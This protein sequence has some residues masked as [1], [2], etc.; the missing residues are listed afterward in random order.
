[1]AFRLVLR[2]SL[3]L[4]LLILL[5][6]ASSGYGLKKDKEEPEDNQSENNKTAS[7]RFPFSW[8]SRK[9]PILPPRLRSTTTTTT[10]TTTTTTENSIPLESEKHDEQEDLLQV[11]FSEDSPAVFWPVRRRIPSR[12]F[13][14]PMT[15][16]TTV[17][18]LLKLLKP[19]PSRPLLYSL[20]GF[21]PKPSIKRITTTEA[22][23][24]IKALYEAR[25]KYYTST[26]RKKL[27]SNLTSEPQSSKTSVGSNNK[28]V[29]IYTA[30]MKKGEPGV[31]Y[32]I[33]NFIPTTNFACG[34]APGRFADPETGC[35]IWHICPGGYNKHRHSFMCPNG[36]I[37]N[38]LRGVCDWW[39]N[40]QCDKSVSRFERDV[41]YVLLS[42][43]FK[44]EETPMLEQTGYIQNVA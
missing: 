14:P 22:P 27:D 31:D 13:L 2:I 16:T 28:P 20:D 11:S 4:V 36:T 23:A 25:N 18:P 44:D 8:R 7:R 24:H 29:S 32:P 35:Q 42:N 1:M 34:Q 39:Y 10:S 40:V 33:H 17:R 21:V 6:V 26:R 9:F 41:N 30:H 3:W 38:E 19:R 43:R 5:C 12:S 15:T 37:Y